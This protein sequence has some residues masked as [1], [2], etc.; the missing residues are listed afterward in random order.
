MRG[1]SVRGIRLFFRDRLAITALLS[2]LP[3]ESWIWKRT[4]FPTHGASC[5]SW[6][7]WPGRPRR[8]YGGCAIPREAV[9]RRLSTSLPAIVAWALFSRKRKFQCA[10]RFAAHANY[11]GWILSISRMRASFL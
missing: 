8:E 4:L 11:W 2:F 6:R 10:T 1:P 9:L 5:R 7:R 3:V